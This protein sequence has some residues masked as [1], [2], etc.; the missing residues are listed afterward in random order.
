MRQTLVPGGAIDALTRE[1]ARELFAGAYRQT[2]EERVRPSGVIVLDG[3]G[4]GQEELYTVPAGFELEVRRIVLDLSTASDPNT[5]NVALGAGKFVQYLRG[6]AVI[7][8]GQPTYGPTLQVPGSQSW[9][10]EQGPYLRNLETFEV[11]AVGLTAG[12]TLVAR[13]EGILRRPPPE[14]DHGSGSRRGR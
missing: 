9:G 10:D 2:V 14:R 7:E 8:Y 3:A 11:R 12:A 5:G 1:E 13:L 4:N 6:G